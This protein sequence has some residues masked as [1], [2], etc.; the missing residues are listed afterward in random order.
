MAFEDLLMRNVARYGIRREEL[1]S[2]VR[3]SQSADKGIIVLFANFDDEQ[4]IFRQDSSFLYYTGLDEP[5]VAYT[6]ELDGT[7]TLWIADCTINRSAW[8]SSDLDFLIENAKKYGIDQ[9]RMLG[10]KVAK[11]S[12]HP[13]S[14]LN[15]YKNI[16]DY[17]KSVI[18][19]G[20]AFF[21]LNP[22]GPDECVEQRLLLTRF[23]SLS[24]GLSWPIDISPLV[25]DMR[26]K[27]D[28][29]EIELLHQAIDVTAM[30]QEAAARSIKQGMS[31]AEIKA[32]IEYVFAASGA[33]ISFPSI[34]GTGKNSTILHYQK[35]ADVLKDGDLVL[36]DCGA[37]YNHYC[38]DLTRTYPVSGFFTQRQKEIYA[39]VLEVQEYIASIAMPGF[40]LS[41][42][43]QKEKSLN[44]LAQAYFAEKGYGSYFIHGIGHYLGI[45]VHDVGD[46]KKPLAEGDVFTIE[47]G[48]YIP[49]EQIGIRIEDNYWMTKQGVI[50]LSEQLPKEIKEIEKMVQQKLSK[51]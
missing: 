35:S 45:D 17:I 41:N 50:C 51:D 26:C 28:A 43:D 1:V 44:H 6:I 49:Q 15:S 8:Y 14:S 3:K 7:T 23:C 13:F 2:K 12:V 9:V 38:G 27:K 4:R 32:N 47:P 18:A 5:G 34:V 24:D 10:E 33:T 21:S 37:R 22:T 29:Y 20:G 42:A 11:Y 30:A 46:Y 48:L 16:I 19:R 36:I 25:A 39:L 31:E 40:W